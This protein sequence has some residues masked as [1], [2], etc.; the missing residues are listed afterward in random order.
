[1]SVKVA[2]FVGHFPLEIAQGLIKEAVI[3]KLLINVCT[4]KNCKYLRTAANVV[5]TNREQTNVINV[6]PILVCSRNNTNLNTP[7]V[8]FYIVYKGNA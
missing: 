8:S 6:W 4:L 7:G 2:S 5:A 3:I 1:M